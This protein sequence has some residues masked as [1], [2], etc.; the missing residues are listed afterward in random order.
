MRH[1]RQQLPK[2][3]RGAV[4]VVVGLAIFVLVGMIGLALDSGQ[5]F[6]NKTE[7]Q[8]AADACAL[9]A[10]RELDGTSDG[11][12]RGDAAGKLIGTKNLVG[13]QKTPVVLQDGDITY[14]DQLASGFANSFDPSDLENV[15]FAKCK[16]ERTDIRTWFM[17]L[18]GYNDPGKEPKVSASAV[19]TLAPSQT[20]CALP[21]GFCEN[22]EEP[23]EGCTNPDKYGLCVG[24]W[25]NGKFDAKGNVKGAFN[26][27]DFGEA[28]GG[29]SDLSK[30]LIKG[31]CNVSSDQ[32]VEPLA[33]PGAAQSAAKAWNSRFGLYFSDANGNN[34]SPTGNPPAAQ[35]W[36]GFSYT[37]KPEGV[38]AWLPQ[39]S[40]FAD[41]LLHRA[42]RAPYQGD[43]KTG[44][45]I[46]GHYTAIGEKV[47][48]DRR[49]VPV[50][51]IDCTQWE[52]TKKIKI[53]DWACVL[54]LHP[55]E[56][57]S[58]DPK[59]DELGDLYMEYLGLAS[60]P[61]SPCASYGVGGGTFGPLV[62][63]LVQ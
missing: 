60:K 44:L 5:L 6:V 45:K 54:L 8:N 7:L 18:F 27:I 47:E 56:I 21:I 61:G 30:L 17:G 43:D 36:T 53:D 42:T 33:E 35:D 23:L 29:K 40:A 2:R 50:P 19:A 15:K 28:A 34:P 14:S 32:I 31:Q 11:L 48:A 1:H 41:Y 46:I 63:V 52:T 59:N 26:W 22:K 37:T 4:A 10:A 57:P 62:P 13:F 25:R 39:R 16:V 24:D 55:I 20:S 3:Q 49:V 9:A 12:A 51:M 58:G 38:A